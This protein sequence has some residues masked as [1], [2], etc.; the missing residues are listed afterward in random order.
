MFTQDDVAGP[1]EGAILVNKP[2]GITSAE[3]VRRIKR[4][5]K[6]SKVG[7]GGTLDPLATGLLTIL[8]GRATKLQDELLK[9]SKIYRGRIRL[10]YITDTDDVTGELVDG[11]KDFSGISREEFQD[12]LEGLLAQFSG[13]IQQIPPKVS[14]LK[15]RGQPAY[16]RVRAGEDV[17]LA[18]RS[19]KI[20]GLELNLLDP[21]VLEYQVEVS[22]G[23]YVRSLAR[24]IGESLGCL[25]C[26]ES[27][28]RLKVGEF[29]LEDAT[30]LELL[31]DAELTPKFL[32]IET[33]VAGLHKIELS[34]EQCLDLR[35]G[36]QGLLSD[37]ESPID[38]T[39][40][41]VFSEF[42]ELCALLEK[43]QIAEEKNWKIKTV[44]N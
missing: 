16:K 41:V 36:K 40:A 42:G 13:E 24:D 7:H 26:L 17:R 27:I 2:E 10:G 29:H 30:D 31:Q 21:K 6:L 43:K 35:Q 11:S 15:V 34:N 37:L 8:V 20:Y 9:G 38:I 28:E 19:V 23:F 44:F 22:S 33:L 3:V 5:H 18:A 25:G 1:R 4:T 32:A 12:K 14:A 39:T